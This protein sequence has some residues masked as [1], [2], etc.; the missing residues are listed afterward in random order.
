[1]E[2]KSIHKNA[3]NDIHDHRK[4]INKKLK[5]YMAKTFMS[6]FEEYEE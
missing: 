5:I 6:D 4:P 3:H 1:M 2:K